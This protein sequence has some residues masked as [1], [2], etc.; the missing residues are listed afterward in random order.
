MI[1]VPIS[2]EET[3]CIISE[4]YPHIFDAQQKSKQE[5]CKIV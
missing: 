4:V 2:W 3:I 1:E 5:T